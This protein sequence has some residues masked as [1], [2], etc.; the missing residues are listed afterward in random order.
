MECSWVAPRRLRNVEPKQAQNGFCVQLLPL[1]GAALARTD[2][3]ILGEAKRT[4]IK[5]M[6]R[7]NSSVVLAG[8]LA[9]HRQRASAVSAVQCPPSPPESPANLF[10]P[11]R[12]ARVSPPEWS[13]KLFW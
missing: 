10:L 6:L 5:V 7:N 4:D 1:R 12:V 9:V 13:A 11:A 2:V 8:V 3:A